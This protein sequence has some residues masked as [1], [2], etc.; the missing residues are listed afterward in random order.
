MHM[1]MTTRILQVGK[2][3]GFFKNRQSGQGVVET[4]RMEK[5]IAVDIFTPAVRGIASKHFGKYFEFT[6]C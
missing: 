1:N 4:P 2:K 6:L 3:I 5:A